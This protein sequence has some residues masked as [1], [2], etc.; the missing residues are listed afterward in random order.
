MHQ[1]EI[2]VK[3]SLWLSLN[4]ISMMVTYISQV[5][6]D[7]CDTI[8]WTANNIIRISHFD[9]SQDDIEIFGKDFLWKI[10]TFIKQVKEWT[11]DKEKNKY[12]LQKLFEDMWY[13]FEQ[14]FLF[15]KEMEIKLEDFLSQKM[16]QKDD[17]VDK[18]TKKMVSLWQIQAIQLE[19]IKIGTNINSNERILSQYYEISEIKEQLSLC[20]LRKKILIDIL[21]MLYSSKIVA[22]NEEVLD[23]D[24]LFNGLKIQELDLDIWDMSFQ[25]IWHVQNREPEVWEQ[26][27][28]SPTQEEIILFC[29]KVWINYQIKIIDILP[30][31][32]KIHI[33]IKKINNTKII[34]DFLWF[35]EK[36][37][38][39]YNLKIILSLID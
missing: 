25:K 23:S 11:F 3:S 14:E 39:N 21:Q 13:F 38:G 1:K 10:L 26:E 35:L 9:K 18:K 37:L 16:A 34:M 30:E 32:R 4:E 20:R 22:P 12:I 2:E 36:V 24:E 17:I 7:I 15:Y 33:S 27:D 19:P 28:R 5:G 8:C 31:Q 6:R 29:E